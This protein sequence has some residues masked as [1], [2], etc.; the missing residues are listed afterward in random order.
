MPFLPV[1]PAVK[2]AMDIAYDA[3]EIAGYEIVD[4]EL[5]EEDYNRGTD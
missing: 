2:R 4:F 5:T 1:C 3:L